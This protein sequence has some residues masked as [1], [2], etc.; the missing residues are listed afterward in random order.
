MRARH[1]AQLAAPERARA[2]RRARDGRRAADVRPAQ[3]PRGHG[4]ADACAC[5]SRSGSRRTSATRRWRRSSRSATSRG[6]LWRGG[7]AKFFAD[8][9]ID[10]GTAWLQEPDTY[11]ESLESFWPEPERL[12]YAITTF[13]NAGFQCATH[14]IGDAAA[15]F[16]LNV[17]RQVDGHRHRLEHLETL[18]DDLVGRDRAGRHHR[19]DAAAAP[20]DGPRRRQRQLE[21]AARPASAPAAPSAGRTCSTRAR[22]LAFGSDWPVAD[23]DPRLGLAAAQ[24]RRLPTAELPVMPEQGLTAEQALAAYTTGAAYAVG[25]EGRGRPH[26]RRDARRPHRARHRSG[27]HARR[28][29]RRRARCG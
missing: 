24:L 2:H 1:V 6:T 17:Y 18:P 12:A 21:R 10:T 4:R 27:G 20:R 8:G 16:V 15:R 3:G 25:D 13:A 23:A 9:V 5:A 7:V 28:G 14:T 22:P 26:P 11:G 29:D 19:L